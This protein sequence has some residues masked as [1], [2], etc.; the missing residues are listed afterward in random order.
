VALIIYMMTLGFSGLT[1]LIYF[2]LNGQ[3]PLLAFAG[4]CVATI[5]FVKRFRLLELYISKYHLLPGRSISGF[6]LDEGDVTPL[7][8]ETGERRQDLTPVT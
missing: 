7:K 1:L 8:Q 3:G 5:L 6:L 2:K 4:T